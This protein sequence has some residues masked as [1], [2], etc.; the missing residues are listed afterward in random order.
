MIENLLIRV[1]TNDRELRYAVWDIVQQDSGDGVEISEP[2][3]KSVDLHQIHSVLV[4]LTEDAALLAT[5]SGLA[6]RIVHNLAGC[7]RKQPASRK[8]RIGLK[9]C[10]KAVAEAAKIFREAG[11]DVGE[12]HEEEETD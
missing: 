8:P 4:D 12:I 9:G 11:A 2:L 6:G 7:F 1:E 5:L 3:A 10:A